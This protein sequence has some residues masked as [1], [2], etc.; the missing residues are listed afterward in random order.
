MVS[1]VIYAVQDA[2]MDFVI[3]FTSNLITFLIVNSLQEWNS[4]R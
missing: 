1:H 2:N 3:Y 4:N